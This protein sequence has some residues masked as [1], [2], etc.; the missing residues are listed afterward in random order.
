M[1]VFETAA[2][3]YDEWFER[4]PLAYRSEL[5]A[6]RALLPE[7]GRGLEIGI[8]TGRFALPLGISEGVEPAAAM[9]RVAEGRGLKVFDAVAENLPYPDGS[10]DFALMVT[11]LCFVDD[12]PG[13]LR[14][15]WRI[16]KPGGRLVVGLVDA[17]SELGRQ[18]AARKTES[19]FYRNARFFSAPA[20]IQLLD[21]A[22]FGNL[23]CRQ[24]LFQGLEERGEPQPI[25]E[26]FG[27]G[28]FVALSGTRP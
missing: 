27:R 13:A 22:G 20:T 7:T 1:N 16:L 23:R 4:H 26:G 2:E 24:T 6:V 14:E 10:F 28:G 8:G 12:P 17:D 18:Y 21:D 5:A 3:R 9:R 15:A 11:T 25:E 19:P